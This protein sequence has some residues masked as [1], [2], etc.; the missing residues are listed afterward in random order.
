MR[1]VITGADISGLIANYIMKAVGNDVIVVDDEEP[2][3]SISM[4]IFKYVEGTDEVRV[5]LEDMDILFGDYSIK[6]GI[7]V[8][9]KVVPCKNNVTEAIH[10]AY[11]NKTR[12]TVPYIEDIKGITDPELYPKR[13]SVT[14]YWKD[15][16]TT[17]VKNARIQPNMVDDF[18]LH[19]AT[20][21]LWTYPEAGRV[22]AM[23]VKVNLIQ[24]ISKRERYIKWDVV[25][26]PFTPGNVIHKI[27]HNSESNI[28]EFS[29]D[30]DED[31]L[32]SDLNFLFPEGWHQDG[33]I[34]TTHG[35]LLPLPEDPVWPSNVVPIGRIAKWNERVTIMNVIHECIDLARHGKVGRN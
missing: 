9:G 26:T 31:R 28:C 15:F 22:D 19:I 23:A 1:V 29:G 6:C 25:Y 8:H 18:D 10:H 20:N 12:L 35:H 30:L 14:F 27:Y 16:L 21:P 33:E 4:P 13:K 34:E 24:V 7:L 32:S 2:G 3:K 17:L 11:W 5:L